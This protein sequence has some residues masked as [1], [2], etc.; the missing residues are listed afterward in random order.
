MKPLLLLLTCASAIKVNSLLL[1]TMPKLAKYNT[2]LDD[3]AYPSCSQ[4]HKF[5]R[6]QAK[7]CTKGRFPE[8]KDCAADADRTKQLG[9]LTAVQTNGLNCVTLDLEYCKISDS[10]MVLVSMA[11][12]VTIIYFILYCFYIVRRFL[13]LRQLPH[14]MHKV[15]NLFVRMQVCLLPLPFR[16]LR[17]TSLLCHDCWYC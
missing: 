2:T 9:S 17:S 5:S 11:I 7:P 8:R 14:Q 12:L 15:N 6:L 13:E 10:T 1:K 4:E 16:L 3:R